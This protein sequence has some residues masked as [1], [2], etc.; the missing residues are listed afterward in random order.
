MT[1]FAIVL[2][3][4]DPRAWKLVEE[5]W[6][7]GKHHIVSSTLAFVS[8]DRESTMTASIAELVGMNQEL[9]IQ[10]VVLQVAYY[11]GFNRSDLWEWMAKST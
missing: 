8:G 6:P 1:A 2:N 3:A 5:H 7:E 4:P 11:F 9:G 10:G